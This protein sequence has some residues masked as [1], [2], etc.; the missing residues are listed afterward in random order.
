ML[1]ITCSLYSSEVGTTSGVFL[2]IPTS[3]RLIGRGEAFVAQVND[4]SALTV[5]PAGLGTINKL[6]ILFTHYEWLIDLDY[7]HLA[8]ATP[9]FKGIGGYQG[10]LGF[11]FTYLHVPTFGNYDEWGVRQGDLNYNDMAFMIGYGQKL[12]ETFSAGL[13]IKAIKQNVDNDIGL[14]FGG[15]LGMTYAWKLPRKFLGLPHTYGKEVKFGL[16]PATITP[17][18]VNKIGHSAARH[19][20]LSAEVFSTEIAKDIGLIHSIVSNEQLETVTQELAEKIAQHDANAMQKI[21]DST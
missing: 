1:L 19:Y 12:S 9:M 5:N 3:A 4:A 7:E 10:V 21:R 6:E 2:K 11:G 8:L 16:A 15:D 18:V 20:F 17:Y 13:V 14:T